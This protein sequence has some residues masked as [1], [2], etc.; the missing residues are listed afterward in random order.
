MKFVYLFNILNDIRIKNIAVLAGNDLYY[1]NKNGD[2]IRFNMKNLVA[3]EPIFQARYLHI[4]IFITFTKS[5]VCFQI[6]DIL[7]LCNGD[8][9]F[10][11]V[12]IDVEKDGSRSILPQ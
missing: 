3:E 11:E 5:V 1:I 8:E 12:Y 6:D 4:G 7:L 2:V 9:G 10:N